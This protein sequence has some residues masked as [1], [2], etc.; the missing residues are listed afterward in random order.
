M[1]V[2]ISILFIVL[3]IN[4]YAII[5]SM[6]VKRKSRA[7]IITLLLSLC[8]LRYIALF[9]YYISI[10]PVYLFSLKNLVFTSIIAI[11][12][13]SYI[14]IKLINKGRLS[15]FDTIFAILLAFMYSVIIYKAPQGIEGASV[16]YKVVVS[17]EWIY[18]M[19]IVQSLFAGFMVYLSVSYFVNIKNTKVKISNVIFFTGYILTIVEGILIIL[20]EQLLSLPII[21]EAAILIGIITALKVVI[22]HD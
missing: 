7:Y 2:Y 15:K 17:T 6:K 22:D 20:N 8:T 16:G 4:L 1:N 10:S 21:P 9:I 12:I 5:L 11:P 14:L 3:V 13:V 18:I 19:S